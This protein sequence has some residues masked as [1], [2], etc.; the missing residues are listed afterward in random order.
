MNI[1]SA[2]GAGPEGGRDAR[3]ADRANM[4]ARQ[5]LPVFGTFD[6]IP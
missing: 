5:S 1:A 2:L 4:R 6:I 3:A